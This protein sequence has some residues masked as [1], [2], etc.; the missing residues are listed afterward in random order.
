MTFLF[1]APLPLQCSGSMAD[2]PKGC[3]TLETLSPRTVLTENICQNVQQ[4]LQHGP[5]KM[6]VLTTSTITHPPMQT[7]KATKSKT[8]NSPNSLQPSISCPLPVQCAGGQPSG[9]LA[10]VPQGWLMVTWTH[11]ASWC[12]RR[13]CRSGHRHLSPRSG[14]CTQEWHCKDIHSHIHSHP[15]KHNPKTKKEQNPQLT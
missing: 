9:S 1:T 14:V 2:A 6:P 5:A 8:L 10:D 3:F 13:H 4:I 7:P 12:Y 15:V 11:G